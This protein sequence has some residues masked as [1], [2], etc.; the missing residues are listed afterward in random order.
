MRILLKLLAL[1]GVG[2]AAYTAF[3]SGELF[4]STVIS[5]IFA[6]VFAVI[7]LQF[8]SR[9][10]QPQQSL[11]PVAITASNTPYKR[12][13]LSAHSGRSRCGDSSC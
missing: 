12:V 3:K 1:L 8:P 10:R 7:F 2:L 11:D 9:R 13:F 6:I 4:S 5:G